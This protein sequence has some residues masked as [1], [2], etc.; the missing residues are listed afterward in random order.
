M[1]HS[2]NHLFFIIA[3]AAAFFFNH[4]DASNFHQKDALIEEAYDTAIRAIDLEAE[5]IRSWIQAGKQG[6]E[7][8][9]CDLSGAT[10]K[11]NAI[12]MSE[13]EFTSYASKVI[14]VRTFSNQQLKGR[15]NEGV[16]ECLNDI[17][18]IEMSLADNI[19]EMYSMKESEKRGLRQKL[20]ISFPRIQEEVGIAFVVEDFVLPIINTLLDDTVMSTGIFGVSSV[21]APETFGFSLLVGL[22]LDE[23]ASSLVDAKG[24]IKKKIDDSIDSLSDHCKATFKE[25]M[26]A[27]LNK[28]RAIWKREL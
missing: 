26:K 23:V 24:K 8:A 21:F 1:K 27:L 18:N 5:A 4:A 19:G 22:A 2:I 20:A 3:L 10:S 15:I 7:Q 13:N 9:A 14:E 6:S 28:R 11:I 25:E 16:E 12:S 17:Y